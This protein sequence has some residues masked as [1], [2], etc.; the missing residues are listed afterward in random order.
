VTWHDLVRNGL[1]VHLWGNFTVYLNHKAT[2]PNHQVQ[3]IKHNIDQCGSDS[4]LTQIF[5]CGLASHLHENPVFITENG[6]F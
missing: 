5:P 6:Y 1:K 3:P 2:N 4:F